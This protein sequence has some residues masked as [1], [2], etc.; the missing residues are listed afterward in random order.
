MA[1]KELKY[2]NVVAR[3]FTKEQVEEQIKFAEDGNLFAMLEIIIHNQLVLS[4]KLD[5]VKNYLN[6]G[7]NKKG[8]KTKK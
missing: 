5:K 7:S 4:W 3:N 2:S 8:K 1:K 6:K